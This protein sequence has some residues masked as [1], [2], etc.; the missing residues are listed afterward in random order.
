MSLRDYR[1]FAPLTERI[2]KA[3]QTGRLS[4]AYIIE[5]DSC[6]DKVKFAKDMIKAALCIQ[7]PGWGCDMCPVCRKIDHDNYE[8]LYMVSSDDRSVKDASVAELQEKLKSRPTGGNSNI[9]VIDHADLMTLRAQN[10]LLKTLEEPNPGTL[11]LLLAENT[12]NLLPTITSRCI[13]YRLG[14][15]AA[16]DSTADLTLPRKIMDMVAEHAYFCEFKDK[17]TKEI[18]DRQAAFQLL[19]GLE[20]LLFLYLRGEE[21]G[22]VRKEKI[23]E[24]VRYVEEARRDL[25]AGVNYKYAIRNLI[26]KIGG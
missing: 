20:R 7:D 8:D 12:E 11:I 2:S 6:I 13:I 9:A 19:D 3:I 25:I 24:H 26:L 10:R 22:N 4:H 14:N 16:K 17:L 21:P 5:G 1:D 23:A 15:Y 18:K